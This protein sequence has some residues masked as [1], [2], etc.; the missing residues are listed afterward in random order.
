MCY[1]AAVSFS[2]GDYYRPTDGEELRALE[3]EAERLA[4]AAG[5][6]HLGAEHLFLALRRLPSGHEARRVLNALG[7]DMA[8]LFAELEA[9]VARQPRVGV[10]K[11]S[12][13]LART[14]RVKRLRK[15]A[16]ARARRQGATQ[17][18][19]IHLLCAV[20]EEGESLPAKRLREA[21]GRRP[22]GFTA[23]QLLANEFV[24]RLHGPPT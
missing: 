22:A 18:R 23:T 2:A 1:A 4:R 11:E 19:V 3:A 7:V 10:S 17:V 9:E 24:H 14:P 12:A 8:A 5:D 16:L 21:L 20:V 15:L 6:G 13:P